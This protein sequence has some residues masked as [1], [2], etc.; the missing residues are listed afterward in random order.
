MQSQS[1]SE[2]IE[3]KNYLKR[4]QLTD[5]A[6]AGDLKPALALLQQLIH[7]HLLYIPFENISPFLQTGVELEINAISHKMLH[8]GRGGYCFEHNK[9][10]LQ[11]LKQLGFNARSLAARVTVNQDIDDIDVAKTHRFNIVEIEDERYI[12][13]VGFGLYTPPLPIRLS[14]EEKISP[15]PFGT[16]KVIYRNGVHTLV[17]LLGGEW[18]ELYRF[19]LEEVQE[20]DFDMA[21]WYLTTHPDSKFVN[22]LLASRLT[23]E[24]RYSLNNCQL[25]FYS[26]QGD[27]DSTNLNSASEL[28]TCLND[29][30]GLRAP[31]QKHLEKKLIQTFFSQQR[32][33]PAIATAV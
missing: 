11:V 16:Y 4:I 32:G 13:D 6:S 26:H 10:F 8:R 19:T 31:N 23:S 28:I 2:S 22:S 25:N 27:K 12:V 24:G 9:L 3:I 20:A 5:K 17:T 18:K 7:Q 1:E 15:H 21:N 30:F 14:N 33:Q 29:I